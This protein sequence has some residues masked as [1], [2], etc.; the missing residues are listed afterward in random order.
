M[1]FILA[2]PRVPRLFPTFD[3]RIVGIS[4]TGQRQ[5]AQMGGKLHSREH[6]LHVPKGKT[7]TI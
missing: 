5:H 3:C 4:I 2:M 1:V 6:N 7:E